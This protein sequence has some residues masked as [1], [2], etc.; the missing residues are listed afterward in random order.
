MSFEQNSPVLKQNNFFFYRK[1]IKENIKTFYIL[2]DK[3]DSNNDNVQKEDLKL[4][5]NANNLTLRIELNNSENKDEFIKNITK[6]FDNFGENIFVKHDKDDTVFNINYKNINSLISAYQALKNIFQFK[7]KSP[8]DYY[9]Q[10]GTNN[11][12]ISSVLKSA[13]NTNN[14]KSNNATSYNKDSKKY[15]KSDFK[16][17]INNKNKRNSKFIKNYHKRKYINKSPYYMYYNNF[18]KFAFGNSMGYY[19][20]WPMNNLSNLQFQV[21]G[22]FSYPIQPPLLP[23]NNKTPYKNYN[24]L[25]NTNSNIGYDIEYICKYIVQIE[26]EENFFISKRIRGFKGCIFKNIII[27]N[28]TIFGDYSTVIHLRGKGSGYFEENGT[29]SK[30]PLMVYLSSLNYSSYIKCCNAIDE[31]MEKIYND[32]YEYAVKRFPKEK[33]YSKYKKKI[34]KYE[35]VVNRNF[36]N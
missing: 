26:N 12:N 13:N 31:W 22:P 23:F 24:C 36:V 6:Y 11:N 27:N 34:L 14:N 33:D 7:N 32:Y 15:N 29:E 1:L 19:P 25:F 17:A 2:P 9:S 3:D 21:P 5:N 10:I 35:Y 30:E 20:N 16:A 4:K 18:Y 8:L 28:C